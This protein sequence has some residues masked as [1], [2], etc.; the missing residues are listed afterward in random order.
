MAAGAYPG[1][2]KMKQMRIFSP[3]DGMLIH[4]R[5]ALQQYV[6]FTHSETLVERDNMELIFFLKE[7]LR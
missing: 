1:F 4:L 3:L 2:I 5:V 6:T 7:T